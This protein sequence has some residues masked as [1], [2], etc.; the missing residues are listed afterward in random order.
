MTTGQALTAVKQIKVTIMSIYNSDAIDSG[1]DDDSSD[2]ILAFINSDDENANKST[3]ATRSGRAITR[4]FKIDFY[5]LQT[6]YMYVS[7][8]RQNQI[9]YLSKHL[10]QFSMSTSEVKS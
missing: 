4:R 5:N 7:F 2:V 8:P 1:G 3:N 10:S 9:P 6:T